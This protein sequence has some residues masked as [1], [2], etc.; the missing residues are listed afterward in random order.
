[1][2]YKSIVIPNSK[3]QRITI[4]KE[5][6]LEPGKEIVILY[7]EDYNKLIPSG[8][9]ELN[10]KIV[11]LEKEKN[12]LNEKIRE[13]EKTNKSLAEDIEEKNI[14]LARYDKDKTKLDK[15][16]TKLED[17]T[18]LYITSLEKLIATNENTSRDIIDK[19]TDE[20]NGNIRNFSFMDRLFNR[21]VVDIALNKNKNDLKEA[22]GKQLKESKD[23]MYLV[24]KIDDD[25]I[26]DVE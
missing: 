8:A 14:K 22:Y 9:D 23:K 21:I 6:E 2:T 10:D 4:P 13:I 16:E 19:I 3:Q 5:L 7:L 11:E 20:Y 26:I 24:E 17:L 15:L 18:D 12:E 25:E 1:M